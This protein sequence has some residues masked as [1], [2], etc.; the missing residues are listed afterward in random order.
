MPCW[1][2]GPAPYSSGHLL[3]A[4]PPR[5]LGTPAGSA[6]RAGPLAL[7][8]AF[9]VKFPFFQVTAIKVVFPTM[10]SQVGCDGVLGVPSPTGCSHGLSPM[11]PLRAVTGSMGGR[12]AGSSASPS[13][14]RAGIPRA[15]GAGQEVAQH[16]G[17]AKV[18]VVFPLGLPS[19]PQPF[20]LLRAGSL[21]PAVP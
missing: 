20:L 17:R 8:V 15:D 19:P 14:S 13:P 9:S 4:F 10:L 2:W 11:P 1:G 3:G 16:R 6:E 12:W 18:V 7:L 5:G 21:R